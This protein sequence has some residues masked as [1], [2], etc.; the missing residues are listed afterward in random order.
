M[1]LRIWV[2]LATALLAAAVIFIATGNRSRELGSTHPMLPHPRD[3][4]QAPEIRLPAPLREVPAPGSTPPPESPEPNLPGQ[5]P[6]P[7]KPQAG[8]SAGVS[9]T[10]W[11]LGSGGEFLFGG[12]VELNSREVLG[13]HRKG[14]VGQSGAFRIAGLNPGKY[15]VGVRIGGQSF[16][17]EESVITLGPEGF[18]GLEIRLPGR[19]SIDGKIVDGPVDSRPALEVRRRIGGEWAFAGSCAIAAEGCFTLRHLAAGRYRLFA[20]GGRPAGH[21]DCAEFEL[22]DG[23][24]LDDVELRWVAGQALV[25]DIRDGG[26]APFCGAVRILCLPAGSAMRIIQGTPDENGRLVLNSLAP[27]KLV[28]NIGRARGGGAAVRLEIEVKSGESLER[29]VHLE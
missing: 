6:V 22:R 13:F 20:S 2:G 17:L 23:E 21:T 28:L 1:S 18:E 16:N 5:S 7:S 11:L 10:G 4:A 19:S 3:E 24:H 26:G 27:G 12:E 9:A 14:T 29:T 8:P 15:F 25:L